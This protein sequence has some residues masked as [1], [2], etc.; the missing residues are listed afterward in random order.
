MKAKFEKFVLE[1]DKNDLSRRTLFQKFLGSLNLE[2]NEFDNWI[3]KQD[4]FLGESRIKTGDFY[5]PKIWVDKAYALFDNHFCQNWREKYIVW[6]ASCG[7]GN[8]TLQRQIS[9]CLQSTL[10]Q[11]DIDAICQK[12]SSTKN[13]FAHDFLA[14]MTQAPEFDHLCQTHSDAPVLFFNNPPFKTAGEFSYQ[15]NISGVSQTG[16]LKDLEKRG[17]KS[18]GENL[19]SQFLHK[20]NMMSSEGSYIALFVPLNFWVRPGK[21]DSNYKYLAQEFFPHWQC[22]DG[23]CFNKSEFQ[24]TRGSQDN[25]AMS[26]T[27]WKK[28]KNEQISWTIPI[29]ENEMGVIKSQETNALLF[30][31]P[32]QQLIRTWASDNNYQAKVT[33]RNAVPITCNTNVKKKITKTDLDQLSENAIGYLNC[34][35]NEISK[36]GQQNNIFS[37]VYPNGH[38][39]EILKTEKG[40]L[41]AIMVYAVR[42]IVTPEWWNSFYQYQ[43]PLMYSKE[44][45]NTSTHRR[46][47]RAPIAGQHEHPSPDNIK[48]DGE[49]TDDFKKFALDCFVFS[50]FS[51]NA[52]FVSLGSCEWTDARNQ[53]KTA[54]IINDFFFISRQDML[55]HA[56]LNDFQEMVDHCNQDKEQRFGYHLLSQNPLSTE[57]DQV[58]KSGTRAMLSALKE[59]KTKNSYSRWDA[60]W[61][62]VFSKTGISKPLIDVELLIQKIKTGI[63]RFEILPKEA[64]VSLCGPKNLKRKRQ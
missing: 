12:D 21:S 52:H 16:V 53:L 40:F 54:E 24:G 50:L 30:S 27:L 17:F 31:Q 26:F 57:A 2:K 47:T 28:Q 61:N 41:S 13:C 46:T 64:L 22:L 58:L 10:F 6:D 37:S 7:T 11:E 36:N 44:P 56:I 62:Q 59:R 3:T 49:W 1:N 45:D 55:E 33:K 51:S 19:N 18:F 60:G 38:G 48:G 43:S 34:G 20:L 4:Q 8:L 25:W 63:L 32:S 5:T 14:S 23:F 9:N 15:S 29:L 39:F 35:G 42:N